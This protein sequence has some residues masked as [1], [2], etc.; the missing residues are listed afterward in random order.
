MQGKLTE[1]WRK[2]HPDVEPASELLKRIQAEKTQ[3]IKEKKIKKQKPLLPIKNEETPFELPE[4]W[5]WCRLGD[6]G[7]I[8]GGGT[9]SKADPTFW[10]GEIP[11]IC[12][13]DM[14]RKYLNDSIFKITPN[15][16][17]NS[18]VKLIDE[19]S[20]LFVVRG[21]ILAHTFPVEINTKPTTINQDMK[22]LTPYVKGIEQYLT[23]ALKGFSSKMLRLVRTSTHGTC[24]LEFKAFSNFCLP[25]PCFSEQQ[26]IIAK[27][28][29]LLAYCDQLEQQITQSQANAEQLMQAVLREAF[30]QKEE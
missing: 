30:E 18:S 12:P 15:A 24:R 19:D 6:L 14:K 3:L 17:K 1:T 13:K 2:A 23:L 26:A 21:M 25:L 7:F 10:N 28:D 22:A 8:Q 16:V 20:V 9:P 4:G 11:W 5:V 29:Q 27:V